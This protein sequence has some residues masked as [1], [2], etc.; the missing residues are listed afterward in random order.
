MASCLQKFRGAIA[1]F[2]RSWLRPWGS[3]P[4]ASASHSSALG[5]IHF[6]RSLIDYDVILLNHPWHNLLKRKQTHALC[7]LYILN[8]PVRPRQGPFQQPSTQKALLREIFYI[9]LIYSMHAE[10]I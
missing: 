5:K 2:A 9:K 1:R 8:L 6:Q 10:F 4:R 3:A 7:S